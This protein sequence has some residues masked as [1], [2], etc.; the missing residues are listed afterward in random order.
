VKNSESFQGQEQCLS[1]GP[2]TAHHYRAKNGECFS[3]EELR[4]QKLEVAG[5]VAFEVRELND[6]ML[7]ILSLSL[8]LS[9]HTTLAP[10][11][12]MLPS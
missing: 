3:A 11:Q 12:R 5:N 8:T 6:C 9:L 2:R 7:L 1:A 10:S 4:H